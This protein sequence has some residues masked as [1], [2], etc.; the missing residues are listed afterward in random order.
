[1]TGMLANLVVEVV[2]SREAA[3]RPVEPGK[4]AIFAIF[5][6]VPTA[7]C[8]ISMVLSSNSAL[9]PV[10]SPSSDRE[11]FDDFVTTFA[12]ARSPVSITNTAKSSPTTLGERVTG[13]SIFS[14]LSS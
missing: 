1:M 13:D 6:P 14:S 8:I 12:D 3:V 7:L 4:A 5:K 2:S 9:A 10:M 11:N